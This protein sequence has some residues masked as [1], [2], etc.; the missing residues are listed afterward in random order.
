MRRCLRQFIQVYQ[1]LDN[2]QLVEEQFEELTDTLITETERAI[3]EE[4]QPW[5]IPETI[6]RFKTL[7]REQRAHKSQRWMNSLLASDTEIDELKTS[8]LNALYTQVNNPPPV[9]TLAHRENLR[10]IRQKIDERLKKIRVEWLIEQYKQL[11]PEMQ[12]AFISRIM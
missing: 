11:S 9:L 7:L 6:A 2:E 12:E 8:D 5:H 1:Q 10:D 3:G 4:E